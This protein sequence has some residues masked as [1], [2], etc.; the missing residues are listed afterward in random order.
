MT[1][2]GEASALPEGSQDGPMA[3]R[4]SRMGPSFSI[5]CAASAVFSWTFSSCCEVVAGLSQ[6]TV[7]AATARTVSFGGVSL[8]GSQAGDYSLTIQSAASATITAKV[9]TM[10]GLTEA[11]SKVYDGT[12]AAVVSGTPALQTAEAPALM[13][14]FFP[15][16]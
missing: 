12:T 4:T 2:S 8:T 11:G 13:A 3:T 5:S 15:T 6:P 9:L 7:K 16:F 14:A 10:S 1:S